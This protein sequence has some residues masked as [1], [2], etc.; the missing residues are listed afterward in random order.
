METTMEKQ[1]QSSA[2]P[3]Q[4]LYQEEEPP[5][6]AQEAEPTRSLASPEALSLC[7]QLLDAYLLGLEQH[8]PALAQQQIGELMRG[9][10]AQEPLLSQVK[11]QL[12][13]IYHELELQQSALEQP[14]EPESDV[15][16]LVH[17]AVDY[18]ESHYA[19]TLRRG[20]LARHVGISESYLN[21]CFDR[22]LGISPMTYL[23]RYR[24]DRAKGLLKSGSLSITEIAITVG[25]GSPA[26]FCR[27]F[28]REVGQPPR[29]YRRS[30][31]PRRRG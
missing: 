7:R 28:Q 11:L 20:E 6:V 21:R 25:F 13:R 4:L 23:V 18:I 26:Y 17:K 31:G 19:E 24:I 27:V 8:S 5:V 29:A 9:L 15:A 10:L 3:H 30:F 22:A 1:P 2:A 12:A 14:S 16:R